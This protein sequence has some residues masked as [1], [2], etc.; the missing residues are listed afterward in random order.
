MKVSSNCSDCEFK[1]S[2]K[3]YIFTFFSLFM[4]AD[5][6]DLT[7]IYDKLSSFLD[8]ILAKFM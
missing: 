6:I 5:F 1:I 7:E 2:N 4:S 8:P 3:L